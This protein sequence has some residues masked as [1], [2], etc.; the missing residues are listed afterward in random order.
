VFALLVFAI[1][2]GP[3]VATT[4]A[5]AVND[6][7]SIIA[8]AVADVDEPQVSAS[9]MKSDR[10][11][12]P[13]PSP[14]LSSPAAEAPTPKSAEAID[15]AQAEVE[16]VRSAHAEAP[17]LCQRHGMHKRYFNVGRRQ[18]WRCER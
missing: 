3:K 1:G 15:Y 14:S 10:L 17:D 6:G 7:D 16:R 2:A 9:I 18:S 13:P 4:A 12:L 5:R 11:P 8:L